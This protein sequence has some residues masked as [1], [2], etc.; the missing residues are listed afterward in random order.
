MKNE[1]IIPNGNQNG[2]L[3]TPVIREIGIPINIESNSLVY[4]ANPALISNVEITGTKNEK[5]RDSTI[6]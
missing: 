3:T 5:S 6:I 2:Q 1:F 4:I